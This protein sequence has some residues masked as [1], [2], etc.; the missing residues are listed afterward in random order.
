MS[1]QVTLMG[2]I[3]EPTLR[4]TQSG[5]ALLGFSMVTKRRTMNQDTK[6]WE[7]HEETWWK[8]TAWEKLAENCAE[9]LTKGMHVIVV[10]R[11]YTDTYT[12][13]DGTQKT[14]LKVSASAI[15]P[16]LRRSTATIKKV[17][18]ERASGPD[19]F[20]DSWATKESPIDEM[21]F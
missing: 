13:K 9:S 8:V 21:P 17:E 1:A 11:T 10:G 15:G 3:S 19:G 16:D 7:D 2:I 6:Q 5:K 4:F 12:A 20:D 18:R 14:E